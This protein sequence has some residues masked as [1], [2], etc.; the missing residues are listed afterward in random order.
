MGNILKQ[1]STVLVRMN[2]PKNI[3]TISRELRRNADRLARIPSD[4]ELHHVLHD[5]AAKVPPLVKCLGRAPRERDVRWTQTL[6][7]DVLP[8]G[9]AAAPPEA[10]AAVAPPPPASPHPAVAAFDPVRVLARLDALEAEVAR[11][12]A[13]LG[14]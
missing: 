10:P 4:E 6:A 8:D 12:K 3:S 1:A 7:P 13:A 9:T 5:L 2:R 14:V 11:L